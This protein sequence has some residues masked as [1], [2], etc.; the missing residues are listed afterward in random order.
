MKQSLPSITAISYLPCNQLPTNITEKHI[1]GIPV[2]ITTPLTPV[3]HYGNASC[4]AEQEYINGNYSE[5]TVLQFTST[6]E[7]KQFPA[8]AFIVRDAQGDTF[9]IGNSEAPY[10]TVEINTK[11]DKDSNI[12]FYKVTFIRRKSLVPC[13]VP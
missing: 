12:K 8:K 2:E 6:Q 3:E 4:E 10:P 1:A 9:L 11:T 5:Q 13:I 7:I